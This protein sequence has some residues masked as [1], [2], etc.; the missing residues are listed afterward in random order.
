MNAR[1]EINHSY[2]KSATIVHAFYDAGG[3]VSDV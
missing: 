1:I 2:V 3:S